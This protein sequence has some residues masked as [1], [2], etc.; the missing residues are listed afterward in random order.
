MSRMGLLRGNDIKMRYRRLDF[1]CTRTK[2][3]ASIA[4]TRGTNE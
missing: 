4:I 1:E 2:T 3:E